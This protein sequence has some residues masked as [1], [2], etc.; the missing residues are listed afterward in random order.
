MTTARSQA[1]PTTL[2]LAVGALGGGA[3]T[4]AIVH[5]TAAANQWA[6]LRLAVLAWLL[7]AGG[8]ALGASRLVTA[9]AGPALGAAILG[10]W[11]GDGSAWGAAL[12]IGCLW[13]STSELAWAAVA[14]ADG[15]DRTPAANG[16]RVREVATVLIV[17]V[18]GGTAAG[19]IGAAA[20][21]RTLLVQLLGSVLVLGALA[22]LLVQVGERARATPSRSGSGGDDEGD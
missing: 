17:A 4:L 20:P 11:S 12:L 18:V 22:A 13:Y 15:V 9:A 6:V 7:L 19:L 1:G 16:N 21:P 8:V 10:L 14:A 2:A 5:G 3:A